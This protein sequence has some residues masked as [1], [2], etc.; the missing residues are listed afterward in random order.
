MRIIPFLK[1]YAVIDRIINHPQA[2][3]SYRTTTSPSDRPEGTADGSRREGRV[4]LRVSGLLFDDLRG[5]VY[6]EAYF[7]AFFV[8]LFLRFILDLIFFPVI[9]SLQDV[10][11]WKLRK[12]VRDLL[13]V[14]KGNSYKF[15]KLL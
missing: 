11:A 9:C 1:D 3:F 10:S 6:F 15:F 2:H 8:V 12:I 5:G 13:Q 7:F 14:Q 4:L